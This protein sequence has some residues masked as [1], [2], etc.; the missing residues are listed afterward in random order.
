MFSRGRRRPAATRGPQRIGDVISNI[1]GNRPA[2]AGRTSTPSDGLHVEYDEGGG[3]GFHIGSAVRHRQF[4]IGRIEA[5][6]PQHGGALLTIRFLSGEQKTIKS[7]YVE[8]ASE[9]DFDQVQGD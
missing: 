6:S 4:G 8:P 1:L 2:P 7:S 5:V 9:R 3:G